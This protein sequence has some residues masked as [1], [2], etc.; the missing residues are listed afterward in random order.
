MLITFVSA[1]IVETF[2]KK[3]FL[4]ANNLAWKYLLVLTNSIWNLLLLD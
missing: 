1:K 4:E 3:L 2:L